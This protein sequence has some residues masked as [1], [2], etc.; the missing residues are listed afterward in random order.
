MTH[1]AGTSSFTTLS[2]I[3]WLRVDLRMSLMIY[4]SNHVTSDKLE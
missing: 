3:L 2:S 1:M 4:F